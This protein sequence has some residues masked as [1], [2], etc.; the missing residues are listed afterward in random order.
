MLVTNKDFEDLK[1]RTRTLLLTTGDVDSEMK[2][3]L[4]ADI[5]GSPPA[6]SNFDYA[7]LL[8]ETVLLGNVAIR[9]G[10]KL[11]RDGPGLKVTD[12]PE[13]AQYIKREYR[14]GWTL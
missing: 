5:K 3:E 11:E 12:C 1:V 6:M 13:A 4:V 8:A 10:K 14:K 7:S 2:R 9:L